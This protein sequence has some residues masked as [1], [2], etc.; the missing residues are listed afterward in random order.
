MKNRFLG[1][2]IIF[3]IC[4]TFTGFYYVSQNNNIANKYTEEQM[5]LDNQIKANQKSID[6]LNSNIEYQA[7]KEFIE[8]TARE[9]LGFVMKDEI[10]FIEN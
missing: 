2:T 5:T 4:I 9:K 7:S 1:M 3:M 10:I 8:K 6:E